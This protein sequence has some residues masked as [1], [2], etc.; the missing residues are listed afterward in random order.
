MTKRALAALLAAVLILA[1]TEQVVRAQARVDTTEFLARIA[2]AKQI[3]EQGVVTPNNSLMFEVREALSLP[4]SVDLNG[5]E[6]TIPKDE[7]L[8]SLDGDNRREFRATVS[9]LTFLET[10]VRNADSEPAPNGAEISDSLSRAYRGISITQSPRDRLNELIAR[11]TAAAL[12]FLYRLL[13]S[14]D[15]S[16][17]VLRLLGLAALILG[18]ILLILLTVRRLRMVPSRTLQ[19]A[20]GRGT[21]VIDWQKIFADAVARGDL[22]E[23]VR[24]R[25]HI[26]L[27]ALSASGIIGDDPSLTAGE[28]R[29]AVGAKRPKLFP[30]VVEATLTFERVAYGDADAENADIE[31]IQRAETLAKAS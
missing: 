4:A 8:E 12:E 30:S 21:Q 18:L 23:A 3:A 22:R 14:D 19:L 29:Q 24:A 20:R 26:L 31:R 5:R 28:C 6:V 1:S 15:T 11:A 7:F 2:R 10:Q 25:Y 17:T 9:H 13:F 16:F 27:G